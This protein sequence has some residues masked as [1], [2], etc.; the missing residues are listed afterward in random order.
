[1]WIYLYRG[2]LERCVECSDKGIYLAAE[3]GVPVV[4]YPSAKALALIKLGRYDA[5]WAS[6]QEEIVDNEHRMGNAM[7]HFGTGVYFLEIM[8]Y[9]KASEAFEYVIEQAR[10]LKRP[11]LRSWAYNK[12]AETLIRTGQL[13]QLKLDKIVQELASMDAA[14]PAK[15]IGEIAL[16]LGKLDEAL[17]QAKTALYQAK[18]IGRRPDYVS[19]LELK[20][21]VLLQMHRPKDCI[22]LS[23]EGIRMA[24]EMGYLPMLLRIRSSKA[25]A[26]EMFGDTE[27]A[28]REYEAAAA[29]IRELAD[30]ITEAELRQTFM[31]NP[32]VAPIIALSDHN[33][34]KRCG[35]MS[36]RK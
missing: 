24:E 10:L 17:Q 27:V 18:E 2:D 22:A 28:A 29:T 5:A 20:L 25:Q 33:A 30:T 7:Q 31:S 15:L 23:H 3:L 21:R 1:M 6:L 36:S 4:L 34:R 8:A 16:S 19:A 13:D 11:W 9:E 14:L 35:N 12:S 32:L 26:F